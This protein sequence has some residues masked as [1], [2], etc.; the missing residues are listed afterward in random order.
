MES[1]DTAADKAK[2]PS[3]EPQLVDNA[4][5]LA[6]FIIL[7]FLVA[8][9]SVLISAKVLNDAACTNAV[10]KA[11]EGMMDGQRSEAVMHMAVSGVENT[12]TSFLVSM[13]Q[14]TEFNYGTRNGK[15]ALRI[16][17]SA[18]ARIPA[19]FLMPN[20]PFNSD[21]QLQVSRA[22]EIEISPQPVKKSG[23]K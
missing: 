13:P 5:S 21:G 10:A 15:R 4:L 12:P 1:A 17:T 3:E 20:A 14:L 9:V 7:F 22:Y 8:N 23:S 16:A 19:P 11:R 18:L 2:K 6:L